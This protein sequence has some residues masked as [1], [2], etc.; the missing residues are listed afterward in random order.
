MTLPSPD[1]IRDDTQPQNVLSHHPSGEGS[2]I[3]SAFNNDPY[4]LEESM[5]I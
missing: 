2:G 3:E 5:N 1:T 4:A